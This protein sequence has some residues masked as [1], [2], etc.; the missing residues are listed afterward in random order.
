MIG[1]FGRVVTPASTLVRAH[2]H[3]ERLRVEAAVGVR[4][5]RPGQSEHARIPGERPI[6]QL[7]QLAI[8]A[9]WEILSDFPNLVLDDVEVV[10]QPLGRRSDRAVLADGGGDGAVRAE[11]HPPVVAKARRQCSAPGGP[12]RHALRGGE[13]LGVLLEA[14]DA[15]EL[16]ADRLCG[17]AKGRCR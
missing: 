17:I 16:T 14:L 11:Q 5:E 6:R 4:H 10:D 12:G 13:T 7:G 9:A 1:N 15:E 3:A 2:E 8:I